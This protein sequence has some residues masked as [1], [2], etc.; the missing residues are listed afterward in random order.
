MAFCIK[1]GSSGLIGSPSSFQRTACANMLHWHQVASPIEPGV[2]VAFFAWVFEWQKF[3]IS[4]PVSVVLMWTASEGLCLL[5]LSGTATGR[6]ADGSTCHGAMRKAVDSLEDGSLWT[7]RL[8]GFCDVLEAI[9]RKRQT[10]CPLV[11]SAAVPR[12][13]DKARKVRGTHAFQWNIVD[14]DH[15]EDRTAATY[16]TTRD[17]THAFV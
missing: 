1:V 7:E 3:I 17:R 15:N 6:R 9:P 8:W 4:L 11:A 14:F 2:P 13:K 16:L 5:E 12:W 10:T